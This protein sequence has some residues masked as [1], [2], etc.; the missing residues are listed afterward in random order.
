MAVLQGSRLEK[1]D[2]TH[3]SE[4]EDPQKANWQ[5]TVAKAKGTGSEPSDPGHPIFPPN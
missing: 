4:G 5:Q 2:V 1:W 3:T